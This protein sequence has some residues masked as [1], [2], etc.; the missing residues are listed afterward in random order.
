MR[1]MIPLLAAGAFFG[2]ASGFAHLHEMRHAHQSA[3]E[4][5]IADVCLDAARGKAPPAA[6]PAD[7]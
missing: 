5:H 4:R 3:F 1:W 2:F 7:P 6:P